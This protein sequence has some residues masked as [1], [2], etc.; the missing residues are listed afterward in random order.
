MNMT[1]TPTAEILT[2]LEVA[3]L[4]RCDRDK[5]YRLLK[6]G[7]LPGRRVGGSWLIRRERLMEWLDGKEET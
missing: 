7:E 1:H 6:T 2:P 5:V 4:L 3:T